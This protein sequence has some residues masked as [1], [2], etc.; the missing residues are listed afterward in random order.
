[1]NINLKRLK[2]GLNQL[3]SLDI[4]KNNSLTA[5]TCDSN[6]LTSLDISKENSLYFLNCENNLLTSLEVVDNNGG[7]HRNFYFRIY[8]AGNPGEWWKNLERKGGFDSSGN[9]I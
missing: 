5:L 6:E 8:L 9:P 2:C 1:M 3:K 7:N 4:S